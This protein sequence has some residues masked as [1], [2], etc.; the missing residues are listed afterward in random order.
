M[1]V[2]LD[3][4]EP[5]LIEGDLLAL[6]SA[7][8]PSATICRGLGDCWMLEEG[9]APAVPLTNLQVF[10]GAGRAW[11]FACPTTVLPATSRLGAA[12]A[13]VALQS[14]TLEFEV[15]LDEE[16]VHLRARGRSC[17][18]DFGERAH[19][20]LLL[21]LARARLADARAG[22]SASGCGW[23]D[24]ETLCRNSRVTPGQISVDVFRIRQQFV[25]HAVVDA[26]SIIE[27]R[28]GQLRIGTAA[29]TISRR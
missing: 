2:P 9:E 3:G 18:L 20:Y 26:S 8:E 12:P 1:V 4:A 15:S 28:P 27:R 6:P 17:L 5:V 11:R 14:L 21:T 16:H 10:H 19:L 24:V 7:D 25:A 23:V 22:A 29:A 13:E